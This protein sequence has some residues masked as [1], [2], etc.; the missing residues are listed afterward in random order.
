MSC[1]NDYFSQTPADMAPEVVGTSWHSIESYLILKPIILWQFD[2]L[3]TSWANLSIML[4]GGP[5]VEFFIKSSGFGN[6][7]KIL[8][9]NIWFWFKLDSSFEFLGQIWYSKVFP[10]LYNPSRTSCFNLCNKWT[11]REISLYFVPNLQLQL[12]IFC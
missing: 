9:C 7:L 2:V 3:N 12:D 5:K 1:K 4:K 6:K 8:I 10:K 11:K